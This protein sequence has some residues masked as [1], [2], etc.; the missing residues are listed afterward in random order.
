MPRRS[1]ASKVPSSATE[2]KVRRRL[3]SIAQYMSD[4]GRM[5]YRECE[6]VHTCELPGRRTCGRIRREV[7]MDCC[8]TDGFRRPREIRGEPALSKKVRRRGVLKGAA[9]IA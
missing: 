6:V 4:M 3:R 7:V 5:S 2:M 8:E 9:F 1:A